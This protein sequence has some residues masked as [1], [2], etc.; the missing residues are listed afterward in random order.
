MMV[1]AQRVIRQWQQRRPLESAN[2]RTAPNCVLQNAEGYMTLQA[3]LAKEAPLTEYYWQCQQSGCGV[4]SVLP[5]FLLSDQ[6]L[7]LAQGL[8]LE[9]MLH[10]QAPSEKGFGSATHLG[11]CRHTTS[12]CV[13]RLDLK[14]YPRRC[15]R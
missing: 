5:L 8:L 2:P 4:K 12:P 3:L 9:D 1:L 14:W 11:L 15:T 10:R 13:R 6:V 7:G